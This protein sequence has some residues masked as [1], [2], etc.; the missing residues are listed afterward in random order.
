MG[1]QVN[2]LSAYLPVLYLVEELVY[3]AVARPSPTASSAPAL[4]KR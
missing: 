3:L 2:D 1:A 4:G